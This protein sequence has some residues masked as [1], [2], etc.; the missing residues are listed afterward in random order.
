[1]TKETNLNY[2][3][4]G[5]P[6]NTFNR[7]ISSDADTFAR[8]DIDSLG[9]ALDDHDHSPGKGL[10]V[11]ASGASAGPPASDALSADVSLNSSSTEFTGPS[12]A[13]GTSGTWFVTG[14]VTLN[15]APGSVF[16]VRLHDG[17]TTISSTEV[18]AGSRQI[19]VSLSG[20][21]A[22]PAGNI[23]IAVQDQS[24][25]TG[26]IKADSSGFGKDSVIYGQRIG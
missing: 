22:N 15:C 4:I 14:S 5:S 20:I 10:P 23:R 7:R 6:G 8:N 9:M 16:R 13:Q 3:S 12:M 21:L 19:L 26:T 1:M 2:G 17:T 18:I 25:A 11:F 24:S